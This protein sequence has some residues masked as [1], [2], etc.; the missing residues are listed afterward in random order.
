MPIILKRKKEKKPFEKNSINDCDRI[1]QDREGL[2]FVGNEIRDKFERLSD[3]FS[4]HT[5]MFTRK[6]LTVLIK[7]FVMRKI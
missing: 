5:A 7:H 6:L 2:A 3:T 4:V 1:P